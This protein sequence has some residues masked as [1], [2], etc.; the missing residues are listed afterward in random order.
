MLQNCCFPN[1]QTIDFESL[2]LPDPRLSGRFVR[3]P[4]TNF[5][6]HGHKLGFAKKLLRGL[7]K[8]TNIYNFQVAKQIAME[9]RARVWPWT[10]CVEGQ[11]TLFH[12][13]VCRP[14]LFSRLPLTSQ[15]NGE[16]V[17]GLCCLVALHKSL[18]HYAKG[19]SSQPDVMCKFRTVTA[20]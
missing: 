11:I 5:L 10:P 9:R 8:Y 16:H 2:D 17:R 15:W 19:R 13:A 6:R 4:Q 7:N 20:R 14:F 12:H 1:R 18:F 3:R